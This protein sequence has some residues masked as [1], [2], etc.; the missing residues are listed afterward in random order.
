MIFIVVMNYG[1][2][3]MGS[4]DLSLINI[5]ILP[6]TRSKYTLID[7]RLGSDKRIKLILK[8]IILTQTIQCLSCLQVSLY[9]CILVSL[10]PCIL[11]KITKVLNGIETQN[12][13]FLYLCNLHVKTSDISN[14]TYLIKQN[15]Q[16]VTKTGMAGKI[17][18]GV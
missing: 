14:L 6:F 4:I 8:I 10:Y 3:V 9:P 13:L 18:Q 16:F 2:I 11:E 15:L 17:A 7:F 5:Y 1:F 12:V